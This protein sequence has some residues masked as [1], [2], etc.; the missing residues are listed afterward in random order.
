MKIQSVQFEHDVY[1]GDRVVDSIWFDE[2]M[3]QKGVRTLLN[4][5]WPILH[6]LE[7][8]WILLV[9]EFNSSLHAHLCDFIVQKIQ[10]SS[11]NTNNAQFI[12]ATHD[13]NI[14]SNSELKKDQIW[15]TERDK[16]GATNLFSL[17]DFE[18][19]NWENYQVKYLNGRFGA[20][21]FIR[22]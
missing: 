5:L 20:I 10:D 14:L 16:Y 21:P 3:N 17:A 13:T 15:F 2:W 9:D 22:N 11:H 18:I 8:W 1:D 12:F 7:E 6:T 4:I 19:R